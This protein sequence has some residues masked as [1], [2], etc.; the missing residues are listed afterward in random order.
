M[1]KSRKKFWIVFTSIIASVVLLVLACG[2]LTK[3]KTV[4]VEFRTRANADY[5]M[6]QEG[7]LDK[8]ES[9]GEFN[10]KK[11]V[12]FMN[13]ED[14]IEKIEKSNPYIKVEQ[15]IR[16]FPNIVK[17]YVSERIPKFR[18]R[19]E[20]DAGKWYILDAD[21]KVLDMVT[22]GEAAVKEQNYGKNSSFYDATVEI[23]PT[24]FKVTAHIG[25]FVQNDAIKNNLNE[26]ASGVISTLGDIKLV[27]S[28]SVSSSNFILTMK[29]SGINNDNGCEIMIESGK[30]LKAKAQA[31]A[32]AY[33]AATDSNQAVDLS[34]KIITITYQ[35][36]SYLGIMSDKETV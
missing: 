23:D 7:V 6:L 27:K 30:N 29:N 36:G 24:T 34:G 10:Y 33:A 2:L 22:G 11:S 14:N 12:L 16:H 28:V 8:V 15:I 31:G 25:S 19:D 35:N 3:L 4:T 21:F 5:T 17:V 18:V 20:Q 13:F 9:T 32:L 1:Q 26:I